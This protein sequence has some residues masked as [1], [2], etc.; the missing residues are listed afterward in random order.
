MK[1]FIST[2]GLLILTLVVT[3]QGIQFEHGDWASVKA[4][5]QQEEKTIFIDFYT[6]WCGP[7]KMMTKN[8]FPLEKVGQFYNENFICYKL[9]AEKGEGIAL[10]KKYGVKAYPTY[11]FAD[12][13]GEFLHLGTGSMPADG[14][15][16]VGKEALNPAT[17]L[18]NLTKTKEEISKEDMPR[19]LQELYDKNLPYDEKFQTYI[20]SL[21]QD[22][23]ITQKSFDLL[24]KFGGNTA[25]GF[26][27]ETLVGNKT[28][29]ENKLGKQTIENYFYRKMLKR[30]YDYKGRIESYAPVFEEA[31]SL[32]YELEDKIEQTLEIYGYLKNNPDDFEGFVTKCKTFLKAYEANDTE[33]KDYPVFTMCSGRFL[34][35][36]TLDA[37][38]YQLLSEF[39]ASKSETLPR[40]YGTIANKYVE[41]NLLEKGLGYFKKAF[42]SAEELG[43]DTEGWSKA[44]DY[45][46]S[47][48]QVVEKG[49]YTFNG[50]GF[51]HYNGLTVNLWYYSPT[52]NGRKERTKKITIKDGKFSLSGNTK[53]P[54]MGGWNIYD[55]KKLVLEGDMVLE[56]GTYPLSLGEKGSFEVENSFYNWTVYNGWKTFHAYKD[57][58]KKMWALK[59][60]ANADEETKKQ[61]EAYQ[62]ELDEQKAEYIAAV[63]KKSSDPVAKAL[64][65]FEGEL[66]IN[67]GKKEQS[68]DKVLEELKSLIPDYYLVKTMKKLQ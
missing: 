68:G 23:L 53:T 21:S 9:D 39:E 52:K 24:Q 44:L 63:Y 14:F 29:F 30:V 35:N 67:K 64:L 27:Y 37:Y 47:R 33:L 38:V 11:I 62:Q 6:S 54:L 65:A 49:E 16:K 7:C 59:D 4:K 12:A 61:I 31:R 22:E 26:A 42:S 57:I 2:I 25:N 18:V 5:A 32:G 58:E 43:Q 41:A 3:A 34:R 28:A 45:V 10:A 50:K 60:K 36:E 13:N 19:H 56:A 51:E 17:Q 40:A 20:S 46:N 55:G 48:I 66:Y 8:I 15:I 1:S